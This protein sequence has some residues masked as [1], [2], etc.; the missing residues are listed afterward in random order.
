MNGKKN[1]IN[2]NNSYWLCWLR[3][4]TFSLRQKSFR[5]IS[6]KKG[7]EMRNVVIKAVVVLW[8][9]GLGAKWREIVTE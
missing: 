6:R 9:S 2:L 4:L 5:S 3:K 8:Y 7:D 1:N